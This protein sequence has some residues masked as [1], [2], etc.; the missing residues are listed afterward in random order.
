MCSEIMGFKFLVT[1]YAHL[2]VN[3]EKRLVT[4]GVA[5]PT[6]VCFMLRYVTLQ[7]VL[8][9]PLTEIEAFL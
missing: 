6:A 4:V 3:M 1:L 8:H 9:E 2:K 5:Y 7:A